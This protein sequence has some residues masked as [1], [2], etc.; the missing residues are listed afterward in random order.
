MRRGIIGAVLGLLLAAS[1]APAFA[2]TTTTGYVPPGCSG[3]TNLGSTQPGGTIT[4][5]I[6]QPCDFAGHQV[7]MSVNG[8]SGGTK[9]ANPNG[10][11]P[12]NLLV[13]STTQGQLNDPVTVPVHLGSNTITATGTLRNG[14][15]A[16]V[17]GVFTVTAPATATTAGPAAAPTSRVA[18]TGANILR[19]SLAAA[20]LLAIGALMVWGSRRRRSALDR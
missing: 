12:V 11:V 1:A 15:T 3:T 14:A 7:T 19:W 8:G 16:T 9:T 6:G 13:Q 17:T 18:F 10:G 4:G 5:T 2:Q 20:A